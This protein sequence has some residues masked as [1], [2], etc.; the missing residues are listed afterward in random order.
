MRYIVG[1]TIAVMVMFQ[2]FFR[3]DYWRSDHGGGLVYERDNLTG[4]IYEVKA[5]EPVSLLV[6]I[7]G[8]QSD[9]GLASTTPEKKKVSKAKTKKGDLKVVPTLIAQGPNGF[10]AANGYYPNT[11]NDVY[12]RLSPQR[13]QYRR[14]PQPQ[15]Q[16]YTQQRGYN[17]SY[18]MMMHANNQGYTSPS[19]KRTGNN[20]GIEHISRKIDLN[21]DGEMEHIIQT[22]DN[23]GF[24]DISIVSS[25]GKEVFFGRGTSLDILATREAGWVDIALNHRNSQQFFRWNGRTENYAKIPYAR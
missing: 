7:L 24:V 15:P 20:S 8:R 22:P 25:S 12:P 23:A 3:Y 18:N 14:P 2:L 13:V 5:N 4:A 9:V 19:V 16:S 21:G 11:A 17:H 1:L 6:R 10:Q